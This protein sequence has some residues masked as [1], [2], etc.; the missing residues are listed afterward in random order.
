MRNLYLVSS[1]AI[2]FF[3]SDPNVN[4][5]ISCTAIDL[6]QNVVY[7]AVEKTDQQGNLDVE[8][9]R[10]DEAVLQ[11]HLVSMFTT[12]SSPQQPKSRSKSQLISLRVVQETKSMVAVMRNGDILSSSV[13]DEDDMPMME[14][15]G[16]IEDGI[17]AASWSPDD[18][19]LALVTD[20]KKLILMSLTFDVISESPLETSEFGLETPISVGWGSKQTQFHG[21]LGKA[22]AQA[23]TSS[24]P[25]GCS[26]D[27]D[28]TPRISWRGDG[29]H[30]VV[31]FV[32]TP[33]ASSTDASSSPTATPTPSS[34]RHRVLRVYDHQ[35]ILQSTSEA[36]PG[37]EYAL[38]WRPSGNL[39]ASTQR[40]GKSFQGGG[41]GREGKHDIVFFERNGLR[42]GEFELREEGG[43]GERDAGLDMHEGT[44]VPM[45]WGYR[46][47]EVLWSSD[48][49]VLAVWIE[50]GGGDQ[51][52]IVQ[53][54]TTGNYHWHDISLYLKQEISAPVGSSG[55]T[56]VEWHPETALRLILTTSSKVIVRNYSWE[57]VI[58]P[59]MA[60]PT[61]SGSV[62][63]VDGSKIL[64]TPFRTQNVPPPMSSVQLK[65]DPSSK[66]GAKVP[67]HSTF[68][69][70]GRRTPAD[71][72]SSDSVSAKKLISDLDSELFAL[73]WEHG[74]VE[75]YDLRTR[76]GLGKG[77]VIDP[78][79]LG[80]VD[81]LER[82]VYR[83]VVMLRSTE[84]EKET[85]SEKGRVRILVLGSSY[86]VSP[87]SS[88]G[89]NWEGGQEK[90][91]TDV[92]FILEINPDGERFINAGTIAL[93][94]KNGRLVRP[95]DSNSDASSGS[96]GIMWQ[97]P[98][99][100][101][102]I[103]ALDTRTVSSFGRFPEYCD[104]TLHCRFPGV[105]R[106]SPVPIRDSPFTPEMGADTAPVGTRGVEDEEVGVIC[107]GLTGLGKLYACPAGKAE[108]EEQPGSRML[109]STATSFTIGSG[110]LIYTTASANVHE[111]VF[112][113]LGDLSARRGGDELK[114]DIGGKDGNDSN[115]LSGWEKRRVERGSKIVVCVPSEMRLVLQM[116]RGNL[117]TIY[118]R[119]LVLE[120]IRNDMES[121]E[122]RKAFA[123]C[124]KHRI[125][126]DFLVRHDEEAFLE[127]IRSGRFVDEVYQVDH[128]N[129]FL[130]AIGQGMT[131]LPLGTIAKISDALREQLE[132]K[133]LRTYVNSILTA[134]VI[135][136]PPDYESALGLLL[137]LKGTEPALVEDAVKYIIFLVDADKLF[138]TAL[139][140]YD[141]E[142]VLMVAQHSQK[143]PRE[144]LPFLRELRAIKDQ[145]YQWFR[146][147]DYLK[148]Y[149]SA[150]KNLAQAGNDHFDEAV[151]YAERYS[152]YEVALEIWKGSDHYQDILVVYGDWLF[153]RREFRQA[154]SFFVEAKHPQKAMVAYEKAFEWQDLFDL[155]LRHEELVSEE[156]V[157]AMAYRVSE[158]LASKKR[159]AEA[160]RVILDYTTDVRTAVIVL[161]QGNE[162]S[163]ALR[164]TTLKRKRE[165]VQDVIHP[166]ALESKTQIDED[167]NEM[168]EQLRKQLNRIRELRVKKVEEPEEFY[169]VEDTALHNVDVMTDI[170]M[171]PTAFTRYTVAPSTASRTSKRSSRSKRKMERKVGSGRKGTVDE[172]EYLLKSVA[173]LVGRFS[174]T[175]GEGK[176]LL[177]HL[178]K[179][180]AEHR[181]EGLAM[182]RDLAKFEAELGV[183]MDEIWAVTVEETDEGQ[184]AAPASV[185]MPSVQDSWAA[186]MEETERL[187]RINPLERV[188][189]P[190]VD[191]DGDGDGKDWK[192]KLL[193]VWRG[194]E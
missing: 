97:S 145:N 4:T 191:A 164:L 19:L 7:V 61:D 64:I 138:D 120:V 42:H 188:A 173:K 152:L 17:L 66:L 113:P 144:Y 151:R 28:W 44:E 70:Q 72:M 81:L 60:S 77:K 153:E 118:P 71:T 89:V 93:P 91:L 37:L 33:S 163:E 147:D 57:T 10:I 54:W 56:S 94:S 31:S 194:G 129:L 180:T 175:R 181:K 174:V 160:A 8:I 154:A 101:L 108:E 76:L 189:R 82:G 80:G 121:G 115:A 35:A 167:L 52:D 114:A 23:S 85:G 41:A 159:Y 22:A 103:F 178:L 126:L 190:Q 170:S 55:F 124:R 184:A 58:S 62:G 87:A 21:S 109:S 132:R 67:V 3:P 162:F 177:P 156:D 98:T 36:V 12:I 68:L 104:S 168:K 13:E 133:D 99:G 48:S 117:E 2:S 165:L 6:D 183:A 148:R 182:Q 25:V 78:V 74:R 179:F 15:Q 53:L 135:K 166:G 47:K 24:I 128:L 140:M 105:R 34:H 39:I 161:V 43:G 88:G 86:S 96:S 100:Q 136:S 40:F 146:I 150:L 155:A 63:V 127:G 27:E 119:P 73:L 130:T 46:V 111:A 65:L 75:V 112:V 49:N 50:R 141:F 149:S 193:E 131:P 95:A 186:R 192:M 51:G 32:S 122:Y 92:V 14:V 172:E 110:Y 185:P 1:D 83:Q 107:V 45:K 5:S 106:D 142:L 171:A 11:P 9:F 38:S 125:D 137:R 116:P 143:D 187:R 102:F 59:S 84:K 20:A 18:S 26:P 16:S 123:N 169:G 90:G 158:D 139:G 30:F 157:E 79:L 176:R 29:A 69:S 134:H